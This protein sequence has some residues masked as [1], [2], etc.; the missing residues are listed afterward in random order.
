MGKGDVTNCSVYTE[1][2]LLEHGM[3]I[4]KRVLEKKDKSIGG[5]G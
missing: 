3:K 4:A 2:K 5:G 1:V